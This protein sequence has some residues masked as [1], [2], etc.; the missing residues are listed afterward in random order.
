MGE[1]NGNYLKFNGYGMNDNMN[2]NSN[3]MSMSD[4][5][6]QNTNYLDN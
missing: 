1:R 6:F 2:D 3:I 4:N 5:N